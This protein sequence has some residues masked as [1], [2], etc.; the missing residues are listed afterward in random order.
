MI[1]THAPGRASFNIQKYQ[2][3]ANSKMFRGTHIYHFHAPL[4]PWVPGCARPAAPGKPEITPAIF[5]YLYLCEIDGEV[6]LFEITYMCVYER[7]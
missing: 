1:P 7:V 3:V 4:A 6:V 5:Q 2:V